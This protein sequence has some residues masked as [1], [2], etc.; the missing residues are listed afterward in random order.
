MKGSGPDED[1]WSLTKPKKVF[2]L[3]GFGSWLQL[4][5]LHTLALQQ[6]ASTGSRYPEF[7]EARQGKVTAVLAGILAVDG[8]EGHLKNLGLVFFLLFFL[9]VLLPLYHRPCVHVAINEWGHVLSLSTVD[10]LSEVVRWTWCR[11]AGI[12]SVFYGVC[13][14]IWWQVD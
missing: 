5:P 3:G 11:K 1:S 12:L 4:A 8:Y 14:R 6:K 7:Q 9:W 13:V 10:K 2:F